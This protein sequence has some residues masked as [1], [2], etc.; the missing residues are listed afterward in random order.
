MWR[1]KKVSVVFPTYNEKDSIRAAIEEFFEDGLVDEIVVVNNNAA[2]GTDEEVRQTRAR[3][4]HEPRQGY[5][6]AIWRGLAEATGDL[7]IIS[8]P[9]GTF[10]GHDVIK[11]LAYSDD[12]PVVFGTRTSREF[13]WEGANMGF[14]LKFGNWAVGKLM[15]FLFNTTILTDVGCSMRL[16]RREAYERIAPQFSVGGSAFGPQIMLLTILNGIPFIE[17]AVNYRRRVGTSSVTGN[18][19]RAALLGCEMIAMILRYRM[20]SWFGWRPPACSHV[21][22]AREEQTP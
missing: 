9:D 19:L 13:V 4:V 3:L 1:G 6:H 2:P 14:F 5:G 10:S 20:L 18:K 11:M 7:L 16:L 15:E 8:E 12:V 22:S 21:C 17:I